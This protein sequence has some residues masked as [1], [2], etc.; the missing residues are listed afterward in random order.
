M[1]NA[2]PCIGLAKTISKP[3][4]GST[5][6]QVSPGG[7]A[8]TQYGTVE[9]SVPRSHLRGISRQIQCHQWYAITT[10]IA[11]CKRVQT[12]GKKQ[13]VPSIHA[14]EQPNGWIVN[15]SCGIKST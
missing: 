8:E 13:L 6:F 3:A 9:L 4:L 11:D 1:D 10:G 7:I 14:A 5:R 12:G 2:R 15:L